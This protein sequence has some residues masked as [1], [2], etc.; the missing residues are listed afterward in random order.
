MGIFEYSLCPEPG[1]GDWMG[2]IVQL[3][4]Y[5]QPVRTAFLF[6]TFFCDSGMHVPLIFLTG[7]PRTIPWVTD[8]K[9]P[10]EWQK[11]GMPHS[12]G[13]NEEQVEVSVTTGRTV[14]WYNSSGKLIVLTKIEHQLV[15]SSNSLVCICPKYSPKRSECTKI[16]I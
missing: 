16:Y 11:S 9:L 12:F 8:A 7:D 14:K 13:K 2:G 6:A 3:T 10:S 1:L 15:L 4:A 5:K